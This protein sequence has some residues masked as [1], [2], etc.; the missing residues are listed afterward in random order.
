MEEKDTRRNCET[1]KLEDKQDSQVIANGPCP[2]G[3]EDKEED[4]E[5]R[6]EK[7]DE[8]VEAI[9]VQKERNQGQLNKRN[10]KLYDSL[11]ANG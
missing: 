4:F 7:V 1:E 3:L 6:D 8:R 11:Q 2:T 10:K 5:G 9:K